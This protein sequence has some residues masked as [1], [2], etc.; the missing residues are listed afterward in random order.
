MNHD[1]GLKVINADVHS[2]ERDD[3]KGERGDI[4]TDYVIGKFPLEVN[5]KVGNTI[6]INNK[7]GLD[8]ELLKIN[9]SIKK[10]IVCLDINFV[11]QSKRDSK[12]DEAFLSVEWVGM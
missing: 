4:N 2:D 8:L 5:Y 1:I 9:R 7:G 11:F 12:L 10:Y 3:K 6:F